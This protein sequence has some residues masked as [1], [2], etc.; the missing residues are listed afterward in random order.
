MS[1]ETVRL[2]ELGKLGAP[3]LK[4]IDKLAIA[5]NLETSSLVGPVVHPRSS[6]PAAIEGVLA[7]NLVR[8][9]AAHKWTQEMLSEASGVGRAH[10]AHI[11]RHELS[12][13]LD[14]LSLLALAL[15]TSVELL[16]CTRP[17]A[18]R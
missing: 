7:A 4:T 18:R 11:E 15:G 3:S 10:I 8:E 13:A 5:L 6:G 14:T 2:L 9:R 12:P 1:H 16:L 17:T